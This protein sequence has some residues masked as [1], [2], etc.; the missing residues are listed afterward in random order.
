MKR[1]KL[2]LFVELSKNKKKMQEKCA[3]FELSILLNETNCHVFEQIKLLQNDKLTTTS[4]MFIEISCILD[5]HF[6]YAT[7]RTQFQT[8]RIELVSLGRIVKIQ[9][10]VATERRRSNCRWY[11]GM[12]SRLLALM[13]KYIR[14]CFQQGFLFA[15]K[16]FSGV[17]CLFAG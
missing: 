3:T 4:R 9:K 12:I 8:P 11:N 17:P 1:Y 10:F 2:S 15:G 7:E 6:F 5:F 13:K 16:Q 14:I